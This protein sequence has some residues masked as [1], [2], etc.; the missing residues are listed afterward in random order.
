ME[1]LSKRAKEFHKLLDR[2]PETAKVVFLP[3]RKGEKA[4]NVRGKIKEKVR[5]IALT[6]TAAVEW[7]KTGGNVCVYAFPDG[8]CFIDI[9]NPQSVDINRF[10]RTFTVKT[11]N[12]GFHLYYLNPGI[13]KNFILKRDGKKIGELRANWQYVLC[14]GS[15]VPPDEDAHEGAT[16]VYEVIRDGQ[17][18][19]LDFEVVREFI[20]HVDKK[21]KKKPTPKTDYFNKY[22]MSL[23]EILEK[24]EKLKGLL[25][26]LN[27]GY[28]SRS[29]AD[30][31]AV[32]RLI[33]WGFSEESI[34]DILRVC[35][36]Y[37]KTE[38]DDYLD[39]TV[40]KAFSN[41]SGS[42][43]SPDVDVEE[44][45]EEE[46][47]FWFDLDIPPIELR[48]PEGNFIKKYMKMA[49]R[50]TD[51]YPEFH[52][53]AALSIL[54]RVADKK[55]F[56]E[57][58]HETIYPNLW[59]WCLG[60]STISRKTTAMRIAKN[61][62]RISRLDIEN[63]FLPHSF[64][65]EA[66]VEI[67]SDQP[68]GA[69]WLDEAG[70][71]L[72]SLQKPYMTD[73]RDLYCKLY[74]NE[75]YHRKLR[76]SKSSKKAEFRI[77]DPYL[78]QW[79]STVADTFKKYSNTLDLVSGWLLRYIYLCPEYEKEWRGYGILTEE[80]KKLMSDLADFL[81]EITKRVE[82]PVEIL[83]SPE[84]LA[85]FHTWQRTR[86]EEAVK[87]KHKILTQL[88]GRYYTVAIKLAMLFE[89]GEEV[90]NPKIRLETIKEACRI[91]DEYLLPYAVKIIQELEWDEE[92]NLQERILGEL[93][94]AGGEMTRR[95]LQ[96]RLH[97][98]IDDVEKALQALQYSGEIQVVGEPTGGKGRP[99]II[100]KL[101]KRKNGNKLRPVEISEDKLEE[102]KEL[103]SANLERKKDEHELIE[104]VHDLTVSDPDQETL[105]KAI[106]EA[107]KPAVEKYRKEQEPE[108]S[109]RS[110]IESNIL[111]EVLKRF[112]NVNSEKIRFYIKKLKEEGEIS[113]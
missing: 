60:D 94:R 7:L 78:T 27:P 70:N 107:V 97:R 54:S 32:D 10:P 49:S 93:R 102:L 58:S 75:Q 16:G 88:L 11:R 38:R 91:V 112:P 104:E 71:L 81:E 95:E 66:F 86:E 99:K 113:L 44:E 23:S 111:S 3:A 37:E 64:S 34:K 17:I 24:D 21:E 41:Y 18:V 103:F 57:L 73:L 90:F 98:P 29:E 47:S 42:F 43:Y 31:A 100:V 110:Q 48:L 84:S 62:V 68:H 19:T 83:F 35:R 26:D 39:H 61:L 77:E 105:I 85:Y 2:I 28:P 63:F 5:E 40:E 51:A 6:P 79:L 50:R 89:F 8:L 45:E 9:D 106:K 109:P 92:K 20:E 13:E 22:G 76:T 56:V 108:G 67:M 36:S 74:D 15:Y 55:L 33:F 25:S 1:E 52:F 80:D 59:V 4:P 12:G 53:A 87:N 65:P 69:Y 30:L 96:R 14:P 101:K 82:Q 72:A 46:D